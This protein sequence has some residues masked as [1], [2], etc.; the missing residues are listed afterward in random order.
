MFAFNE[1]WGLSFIAVVI[2]G[3]SISLFIGLLGKLLWEW[4]TEGEDYD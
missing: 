1:L 2:I 4:A 3:T